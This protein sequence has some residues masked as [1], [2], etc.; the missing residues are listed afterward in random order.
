MQAE[1]TTLQ[2]CSHFVSCS[3]RKE[4][5]LRSTREWH[6]KTEEILCQIEEIK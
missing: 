2:T 6:L 1:N 3:R 4:F 5:M